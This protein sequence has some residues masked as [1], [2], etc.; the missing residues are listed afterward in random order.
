MVGRYPIGVLMAA[1][2]AESGEQ[3]AHVVGANPRTVCRWMARGLLTVEEAD[4]VC[5]RA[6]LHPG[7]V[8]GDSWWHPEQFDG[9]EEAG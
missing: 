3:L 5:T 4:V 9:V 1:V 8:W 6:G 7:E 2:G